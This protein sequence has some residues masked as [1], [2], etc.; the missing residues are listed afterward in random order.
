[1]KFMNCLPLTLLA[2]CARVSQGYTSRSTTNTSTSFYLQIQKSSNKTLNSYWGYVDPYISADN[3]VAFQFIP[4]KS[5]ATNF[6]IENSNLAGYMPGYVAGSTNAEG[7]PSGDAIYMSPLEL[8]NQ[9]GEPVVTAKI[10]ATTGV[11][12][13]SNTLGDGT[14]RQLPQACF[15]SNSAGPSDFSLPVLVVGEE[16]FTSDRCANVTLYWIPAVN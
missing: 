10:D 16:Y 2:L 8:L 1:M 4:E 15:I 14:N 5:K 13:L 7:T 12:T 6:S 11:V 3:G 9:G